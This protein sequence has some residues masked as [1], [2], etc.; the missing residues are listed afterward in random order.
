MNTRA[1]ELRAQFR[2]ILQAFSLRSYFVPRLGVSLRGAFST[3][4][5]THE[6]RA[7]SERILTANRKAGDPSYK[8]GYGNIEF[9]TFNSVRTLKS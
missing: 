6:P 8:L 2:T 7:S 4:Q 9:V 3:P 5:S 1:M